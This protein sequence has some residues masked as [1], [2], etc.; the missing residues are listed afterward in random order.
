MGRFTTIISRDEHECYPP[1]R[2][3]R[4]FNGLKEDSI[5]KCETSGCGQ[6]W[7]LVRNLEKKLIWI[8]TNN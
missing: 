8:K 4:F 1:G 6:Y 2:L 3:E 5:I 7:R